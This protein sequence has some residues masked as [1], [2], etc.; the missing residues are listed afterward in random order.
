MNRRLPGLMTILMVVMAGCERT[1]IPLQLPEAATDERLQPPITLTLFQVVPSATST[2]ALLITETNPIQTIVPA[3]SP[4]SGEEE[5][6]TFVMDRPFWTYKGFRL[7][8]PQSWKLTTE[9]FKPDPEYDA[10]MSLVLEKSGFTI[11]IVQGEGSIP[12]CL[13]PGETTTKQFYT[14][15]REYKEFYKGNQIIWRRAMPEY[16]GPGWSLFTVC[17][18]RPNTNFADP[19]TAIG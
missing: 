18:L 15:Y 1:A 10:T 3:V 6:T 8:Y 19:F 2:Q 7:H 17:E 5:W 9:F 12:F 11:E 13:Y 14:Q 4:G 16:Q